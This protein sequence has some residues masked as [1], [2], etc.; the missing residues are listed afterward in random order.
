MKLDSKKIFFFLVIV[1][2][3]LVTFYKQS[4]PGTIFNELQADLHAN[5]EQVALL[6]ACFAMSYAIIQCFIGYF[7]DCLGGTRIMI[8]GGVLIGLGGIM[9]SC[10][11]T[12]GM[13]YV[14]RVMLGCS[15]GC[16]YLSLVKECDH[17][18]KE[19]F[20]QVLAL[21]VSVGYCGGIMASSPLA[22]LSSR[23]GWRNCFFVISLITLIITFGIALSSRKL[24]SVPI[25]MQKFSFGVIFRIF[26]NR[27]M[28]KLI[29]S[30]SNMFGIFYAVLLVLGKKFLQEIG[31]MTSGCAATC[32]GMIVI[33]YALA[34]QVASF[35]S[36]K[37]HG[38]NALVMRILQGI[39]LV[40]FISLPVI[41]FLKPEGPSCGWLF[42]AAMVLMSIFMGNTPINASLIRK[43]NI[44][45]ELGTAMGINNLFSYL[46]NAIYAY[47]IGAFLELYKNEAIASASGYFIY[48]EKAY[49]MLFVL[50]ALFVIVAYLIGIGMRDE[51]RQART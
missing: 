23:F 5:A 22:A 27:D 20:T 14:S 19:K 1:L 15:C 41:M 36:A 29:F 45:S 10:L 6:G 37:L 39:S 17:Y 24:E 9:F 3:F 32:C 51:S 4:V 12:L 43:Y 18:Y 46:F 30:N 31:G 13:I 48:P 28:L 47:L 11:H 50:I 42:F 49:K 16:I 44:P 26:K 25:R 2:Y 8:I 34:G 35:M 33:V 38:R 21:A 40:G 7:N